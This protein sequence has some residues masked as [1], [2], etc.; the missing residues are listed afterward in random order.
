MSNQPSLFAQ[1]QNL[2]SQPLNLDPQK[3]EVK[4]VFYMD[5][6]K[7]VAHF[8]YLGED[9]EYHALPNGT[10]EVIGYEFDFDGWEKYRVEDADFIL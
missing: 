4:K 2:S 3:V 5:N 1:F 6:G 7:V 9:L 8:T 10:F